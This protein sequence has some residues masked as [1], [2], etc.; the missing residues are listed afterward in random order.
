MTISYV[1][2]NSA[3]PT[4]GASVSVAYP[5]AQTAGNLNVV[6]IGWNDTT[7]TISSV[8]DTLG[9][10]YQLAVP[11]AQLSGAQPLSQAIYYAA[12]IVSAA[13]GANSA[14]VTFSTSASFPDI[15]IAEYSG[16]A[17]SSP[18]DVG[19]SGTGNSAS[20]S[21]G[22]ITTT[23]ANEVL[24]GAGMNTNVLSAGA[25]YTSRIVTAND[26]DLLE[27]DIVT[28]AGSY[29]CT[30][31]ISAS[32]PWVLQVAAFSATPIGGGGSSTNQFFKMF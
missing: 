23:A 3:V 17:T 29:T 25:G 26:F 20:P 5:G 13:A 12:N 30:A 15:R 9:N 31:G 16:L 7:A 19:S 10:S 2:G 14:M 11:V 4:A 21:V 27:D 1:Q 32:G 18:F 22:P 28:S 8:T 6:A 24:V